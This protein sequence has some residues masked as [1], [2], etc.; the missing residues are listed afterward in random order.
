MGLNHCP[1]D[2]KSAALPTELQQHVTGG[3]NT[4][5]N[6]EVDCRPS[7]SWSGC[8]ESNPRPQLGRLMCYRCTTSAYI[9]QHYICLFWVHVAL[10]RS[11][12]ST[13]PVKAALRSKRS[14]HISRST[15]YLISNQIVNSRAGHQ[16]GDIPRTDHAPCCGMW[17]AGQPVT[18]R[19]IIASIPV[20]FSPPHGCRAGAQI[21][22]EVRI[23]EQPSSP[24]LVYFVS[25]CQNRTLFK[26][27]PV[28]KKA[29]S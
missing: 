26:V 8:R 24:P 14:G 23:K 3:R 21:E 1:A 22:K 20:S 7:G 17:A 13:H 12:T 2:Y 15:Y 19:R 6:Y 10:Y 29:D 11:R 18:R 4:A 25:M 9:R 16:E 27:A 5:R 28:Y